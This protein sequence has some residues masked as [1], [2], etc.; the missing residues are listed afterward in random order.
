MSNQLKTIAFLGA[1]SALAVGA[2]SY[3]APGWGMAVAGVAVLMN[4]GAYFFSDRL[5]LRMHG[6][7]ELSPSEYPTL[8]AMNHQLSARAGIPAPRLF[9]IE[10][11]YANA[12]ATGRG[13]EHAAVAF[14]T[15]LLRR[16][17]AREVAGVLAH[18]LAHVKHRDVLIATVAAMFATAVSGIANVLQLSAFLGGG[19]HGDDEDAS[20]LSMLAFALV[21]PL[22]ATL[23]QLAISRSREYVADD[24]A[25]R[26]T[27][28]P[29]ALASALARLHDTAAVAHQSVP[30]PAVASLFVVS[31]FAGASTLLSL[32][33]T[34]PPVERRIQRLL[35]MSTLA[36]AA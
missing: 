2:V 17:A 16:L 9:V 18:E 23:V 19:Q 31:P 22:A 15:G 5:V 8:H 33:S 10:A 11:D 28:D 14:T 6:A 34:H 29:D 24:T 32:F 30:V 7:R 26:L 25:A 27:H 20:P 3:V 4:L 21:A 12:F 35:R 13:P 1:L 36:P